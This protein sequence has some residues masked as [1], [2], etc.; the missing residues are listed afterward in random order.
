MNIELACTKDK[1]ADVEFYLEKDNGRIYL[2]ARKP[3]SYAFY[4]LSVNSEGV[5]ERY[6]G[7]ES[8]GFQID[9]KGKIK[10]IDA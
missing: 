9:Q 1:N 8:L 10:V 2:R 4:I 6:T 7:I 3:N 5:L